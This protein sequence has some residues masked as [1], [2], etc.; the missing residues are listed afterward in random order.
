MGFWEWL[1]DKTFPL[2]PGSV[3]FEEIVEFTRDSFFCLLGTVAVAYML[4]LT[5]LNRL[6]HALVSGW[7]SVWDLQRPWTYGA[8]IAAVL[9]FFASLTVGFADVSARSSDVVFTLSSFSLVEAVLAVVVF[10][11]ATLFYS[12][13]RVKYTPPFRWLLKYLTR[14]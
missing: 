1:A 7:D 11:V 5:V 4:Y 2:W 9:Q 10:W 13:P 6:P 8:L 12:P 14:S 3:Y